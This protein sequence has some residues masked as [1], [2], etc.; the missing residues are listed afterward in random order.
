MKGRSRKKD[1]LFN[2]AVNC[3]D[4]K[5]WWYMNEVSVWSIN[6]MIKTREN[7]IETSGENLLRMSLCSQQIPHTLIWYRNWVFDVEVGDWNE[8][9]IWSS[10]RMWED[11]CK[12][13]RSV[14]ARVLALF[15]LIN[16]RS[17]DVSLRT[18]Q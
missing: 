7:Q 13:H 17:S 11:N 18:R 14:S 3:Y 1:A 2:D 12:M 16:T 8:E 6:E 10:G 9:N 5:C 15:F 4:C